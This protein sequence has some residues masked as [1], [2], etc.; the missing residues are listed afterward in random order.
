MPRRATALP[1]NATDHEY[2][3]HSFKDSQYLGGQSHSDLPSALAYIQEERSQWTHWELVH[4][5]RTLLLTD[6]T[7][8]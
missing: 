5:I 8:G 2:I 4:A 7:P 6:K 3:V 1:K